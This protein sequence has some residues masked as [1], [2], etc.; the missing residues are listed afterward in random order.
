MV[1]S[2]NKLNKSVRVRAFQGLAGSPLATTEPENIPPTRPMTGAERQALLRKQRAQARLNARQEVRKNAD[3]R[4]AK[5]AAEAAQDAAFEAELEKI[6]SV[7]LDH[8]N[9]A[10]AMSALIEEFYPTVKSEKIPNVSRGSVL[11]GAPR[12]LGRLVSGGYNSTK[13]NQVQAA[14]DRDERGRKVRGQGAGAQHDNE[15]GK[16]VRGGRFIEEKTPSFKAKL[17]QDSDEYV[18]D[19][20]QKELEKLCRKKAGELSIMW[21]TEDKKW[22]LIS[23]QEH[24]E[25]AAECRRQGDEWLRQK[26]QR[27]AVTAQAVENKRPDAESTIRE[28]EQNPAPFSVATD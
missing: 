12:G 1:K 11:T 7:G 8:D 15:G 16:I 19:D 21:E 20:K 2:A 10:E 6:K 25:F 3:E 14:H 22:K 18:L 13:I 26:A 28:G 17:G 23:H 27:D 4:A 24:V 9:F 5:Q